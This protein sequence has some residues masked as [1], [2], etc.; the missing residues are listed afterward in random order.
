MH[1]A[2]ISFSIVGHAAWAPGLG[3]PDEW[4]AWAAAPW[5][6]PAEG[7]PGVRA[8]PAMQR[9]RLGQLGKMALDVAYQALGEHA[10]VPT[11][12]CSRHGETARAIALLDDLAHGVPLSPTAFG[13]SVHNANAGMFSIARGDRANHIALA[14][15]SGTLEHAVIEAC[16]LLA[17]GEPM[18][19]LVACE[20]PLPDMFAPFAD[21]AEEPHAFAWLMARDGGERLALDWTA[22]D[23]DEPHGGMPGTLEVLRFLRAA[24]RNWNGWQDGAAGAGAAVRM[25]PEWI[26]RLGPLGRSW[27][28]AATGL[29][30][31]LFGIGGLLLRLVVFPLLYVAVWRRARRVAA[32]RTIIRLAFRAYVDVMRLLGVLRYDVRGLEKLE[33]RGLLILANHPTLID[34]VFLM[35]FVRNA[36]CIVK[37]ALWN[38][39]FTR[40]PVRAAGY[41]SNAGSGGD[42]GDLVRDCIASLERGGNLIVFPEGT[43]TP[44]GGAICLKRGAAN[45]AVRGARDITP[46]VI[47]CDPPTLGKGEKWWRVPPRRVRFSLEVQDDVP[48]APFTDGASEVI[49]ARRLTEFLQNYFTGKYQGHA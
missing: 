15:G 17:D 39:P 34:T 41:I 20:C 12:F 38:N 13:M 37:A 40:G 21:R 3:T 11:V 2:G 10:G 45:V 1:R 26:A 33:R 25:A 4:S 44:A 8:M 49:A 46:V 23:A 29:S 24:R 42:G 31:A 9:R 19:L 18:V 5:P 22:A 43:R 48:V 28:V 7:E 36:D 6:I 27:R 32:A 14:A 35:A 16:G 47:R 30:F